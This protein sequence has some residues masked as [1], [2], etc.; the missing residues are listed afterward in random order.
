MC[1]RPFDKRKVSQ[2]ENEFKKTKPQ[3]L[4]RVVN[5]VIKMEYKKSKKKFSLYD[6]KRIA[7][8]VQERK[9]K[10]EEDKKNPDINKAIW[11]EKR[12]KWVHPFTQ[13]GYIQ[14]TVRKVFID[15]KD[16][17]SDTNDFKSATKFVSRCLEKQQRG[18]FALEENC[19]KNKYRL[20]GA[21]PK[22]RALEVRYALFDYLVSKVSQKAIFHPSSRKKKEINTVLKKRVDCQILV[23]S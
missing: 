18:E 7:L 20:M 15:L 5:R 16:E 19:G 11:N 2:T 9:R 8:A 4:L 3:L 10:Y 14:P 21:G 13:T 17:K 12:K 1:D 23:E 22:K 6:Q